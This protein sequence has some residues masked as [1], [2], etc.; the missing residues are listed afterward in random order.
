MTAKRKITIEV[1]KAIAAALILIGLYCAMVTVILCPEQTAKAE[2]QNPQPN[3]TYLFSDVTGTIAYN[4]QQISDIGLENT[5]FS[6]WAQDINGVT[7]T[8]GAS[9]IRVVIHAYTNTQTDADRYISFYNYRYDSTEYNIVIY[10]NNTAWYRLGYT[11]QVQIDI[12]TLRWSFTAGTIPAGNYNTQ[13]L[14]DVTVDPTPSITLSW[15]NALYDGYYNSE[16]FFLEILWVDLHNIPA[17]ATVRL[18]E[19]N[20]TNAIIIVPTGAIDYSVSFYVPLDTTEQSFIASAEWTDGNGD[21]FIF[22]NSLTSTT[23]GT[24]P[25]TSLRGEGYE[26]GYNAGYTEGVAEQINLWPSLFYAIP[27][28]VTEL[29][30]GHIDD[31]INSPDYGHYTGGI[32][33]MDIFGIDM[34]NVLLTLV[35]VIIL[36]KLATLIFG[37][38]G[39][40]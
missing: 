30:I 16:V 34:R 5:G 9:G 26:E 21:H 29:L 19:L 35:G 25:F 11:R 33:G 40:D 10:N 38:G 22:S 13:W 8:I 32:F 4:A 37:S 18:G 14:R 1:I 39:K 2:V 28:T 15:G 3:V 27:H 31:D 20:D 6:I 23:V 17:N 12:T 36:V 24:D 7:R